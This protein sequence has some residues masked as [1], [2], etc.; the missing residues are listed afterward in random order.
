MSKAVF[1]FCTDPEQDHVA[2]HMFET[3]RRLYTPLDTGLAFDGHP[4]LK[5]ENNSGDEF[6]FVSTGKVISHD[7]PHYVP[8]INSAFSDCDFAGIGNWHEGMNAP[9]NILI[10]QTTG[11]MEEGIF[12]NVDPKHIRNLLLA[13]E[14]E[15]IASGLANFTTYLEGTHWSGKLHG[16]KAIQIRDIRMP[17]VDLEIGSTEDSWHNPDA[18]SVMAKALCHVFD[19]RKEDT[20]SI[21]CV[22]GVHMEPTW[23]NAVITSNEG[24]A[25][26]LSHVLPNH[27]LVAHGYDTEAGYERLIN[28]AESIIGGVHAIAFHDKLK[29]DY[30]NHLRRLGQERGIPVFKHKRLR[31]PE[32]LDLW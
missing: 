4:V 11:D 28:C 9:D 7:Y 3:V 18:I 27:W 29:A 5:Y 10:V 6:L 24:K 19:Q 25:L 14:Q 13:I 32:S 23:A 8:L 12:G 2:P 22:G 31:N 17:V 26:A 20:R 1:F 30:K 21:L 15:R 16:G